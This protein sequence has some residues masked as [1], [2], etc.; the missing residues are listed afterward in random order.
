MKVRFS[1][2]NSKLQEHLIEIS[3]QFED[4][5]LDVDEKYI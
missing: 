1:S 3:K 4:F 5:F 2:I